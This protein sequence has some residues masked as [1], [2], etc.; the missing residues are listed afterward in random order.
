MQDYRIRIAL[1]SPTGTP[2]QSDTLFGHLCWQVAYGVLDMTIEEFLK[3]FVAGR[4]PFVLSDGFPAGCLPRPLFGAPVAMAETL[5]DYAA[6]KRSAKA[7]YVTFADFGR[8]CRGEAAENGPRDNPW[9][10]VQA[11]HA[12]IS[13]ETGTTGTE[14]SFF[15]TVTQTLK[16]GAVDVY[17]RV[18][19]DGWLERV[20]LLLETL[21]K[22]GFG[23][24]KS[25]GAGEFTVTGLE[26]V[27][28]PAVPGANAFV[29]L[30]SMVPAPEDPT[31]GRYRLR[32]KFGKIS[33]GGAENPFKRPLL[34][35]EPGAVFRAEGGIRPCYGCMVH[36]IAPGDARVVQNCYGLAVACKWL[37][38]R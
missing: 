12:T 20:R 17:L 9:E 27:E 21:S 36:K 34:Q 15:T 5:D 24:D 13:R 28:L 37:Q 26:P 29:N 35:I 3:P 16:D 23:R 33:E 38:G 7:A 6:H 18:L 19:E 4:P 25:T 31:E 30:S 10:D 1:A 22:T 32:T 14:G 11:P 8:L 2:W